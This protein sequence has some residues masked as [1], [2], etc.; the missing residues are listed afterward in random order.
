[1]NSS[2]WEEKGCQDLHKMIVTATAT[3]SCLADAQDMNQ[4]INDAP[5]NGIAM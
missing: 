1:M 4:Q 3:A 2:F 5:P